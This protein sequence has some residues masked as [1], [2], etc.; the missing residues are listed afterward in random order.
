MR[1]LKKA[2]MLL[3][4][5]LL[6][7]KAALFISFFISFQNSN[8]IRNFSLFFSLIIL[9]LS[10]LLI[11]S[12]DT[13]VAFFK[14]VQELLWVSF[15][16]NSILL[17]ID[18]LSFSM[19]I[20]TTFLTPICILLCWSLKSQNNVKSYCVTFLIL[21]S[22]LLGVFCSLD[23]LVF[24]LLFEAVLIPM[25]FIVGFFGSRARKIRASYLLFIY[26]LISSILMFLSILFLF[27]KTGS[28]SYVVLFSH[29]LDSFTE[30]L[31]WICFFSSFAVKMPLF[32]FHI[33]LPEAHCEAPTAGSVILAGILLKLGGYGFLRFSIVLFPEASA[34]FTPMVHTLSIFSILY[35]SLT[36]LQQVDLK[37]IIAY[38]SVGHMGL[39][40]IGLFSFNNAGILGAIILM[41]AHGV[42]SSA[43]FLAIGFLYDRF[44]TRIIKYYSGLINSMPLFSVCFIIFTLGNLGL[45]GTSNFIGEILVLASCFIINSWC[46]LFAGIGM[47][48]SAAYSLWLCNRVIFGNIKQSSIYYLRDLDRRE[49]FILAPF[50][51]LTFLMGL[52]PNFMVCFLKASFF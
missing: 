13:S 23:I 40:T 49:F 44:H 48:L 6:P 37:K 27:F 19:I 47:V 2:Q 43:L 34:Y 28:T 26:T 9:N 4:F 31:C 25:Y 50:V 29:E 33:W 42:V 41:L 14:M 32:P 46:S 8:F 7:L 12:F 38:T 17:G 18:G 5:I 15:P 52:W 39:V 51:I 10:V 22:I 3:L 21:E 30:N 20:L 1:N 16:N 11:F 35:A 36:T 24:Y 45:P